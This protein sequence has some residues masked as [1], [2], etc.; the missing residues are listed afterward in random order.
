MR[1]IVITAPDAAPICADFPHPTPGPGEE[2]LDLVAAGVHQVVRTRASGAHYSSEGRFPN[3]PGVDAIARAADGRLLYTGMARQPWGTMAERM[4]TRL[5][6]EIPQDADPLAIAAGVNPAMSGWLP[7][8]ARVAE[9]GRLGTVL[10][11]GATGMAGRLAVQSALALGAERVVAAGRDP[12]R[13]DAVASLGAVR[14]SLDAA[15]PA[16]LA[17]T[18]ADALNGNAPSIVLDYVWGPVA[19]MAFAA[20]SR[21]GL[22][23]DAA[24]T[25]YTE[26][27]SLAGRTAAVPAELLRSRPFLLVGS[28]AGSVLLERMVAE[29]PHVIGAI[30]DGRL[31]VPYTAFPF[32]RVADAW[33]HEGDRAVLV[34]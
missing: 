25:V 31:A 5:R 9:T 32:D 10:V 17:D 16:A 4:A 7:L 28:G 15:D 13:L 20:L 22:E 14:V 8:S 19:E 26:I 27:G 30:A 1:A 11:L 6:V 24:G 29:F 21:P 12:E 18:L 23:S 2:L 34:P 3:V 33:A